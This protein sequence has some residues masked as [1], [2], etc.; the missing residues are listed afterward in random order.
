M[1]YRKI[2]IENFGKIKSAEVEIAPFMLFVGDNNS[3]KSY[4]TSLIWGLQNY[5]RTGFF[6]AK[7]MKKSQHYSKVFE[8]ISDNIRNAVNEQYNVKLKEYGVN[9]QSLIN[10][11]LDFE[12]KSFVKWLFN[13]D[14]VSIDKIQVEIPDL[15]S[16]EVDFH[17]IQNKKVL[18]SDGDT[19]ERVEIIM[20]VI[21]HKKRSRAVCLASSFDEIYD[22]H[23][24]DFL[25]SVLC[26]SI[27]GMNYAKDTSIYLPA[28][29]TGFMLTKDIINQVGRDNTFNDNQES[30]VT[31]FTRPINNFLTVINNLS[32]YSPVKNDKYKSIIQYIECNMA[33]GVLDVSDLPN[34]EVRYI[35]NGRSKSLP[36]RVVSGVVTELSPLLLLLKYNRTISNM[37]Y[38]E[39][40]IG[41]HPQLQ[42]SIARVLCRLVNT[43]TNVCVTTHS[44]LIIQHIN[45]MISLK[46]NSENVDLMEKYGYT[47]EDLIDYR[48]VRVYQ[49]NTEGSRTRKKT[50]LEEIECDDN[51][52]A[53]PTFNDAL[54]KITN[55]AYNIQE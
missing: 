47:Q 45:N 50:V 33:D 30:A 21:Q 22:K 53:V 7:N 54:D 11:C 16:V 39:P 25:M 15:E 3:G 23:N 55:E 28:S 51:G 34:R 44:D 48:K 31:P 49:F 20:Q 13:T 5:G 1:E 43:K 40:E 14:E 26:Y 35:P 32:Q 18:E 29:R 52:F 46:N 36:L 17:T 19:T 38:E 27:L 4:L 42:S 9:I 10:D 8:W 12:K 41:L 24:I 6:S 37:F 2:Y